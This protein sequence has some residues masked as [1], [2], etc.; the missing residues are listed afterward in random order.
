MLSHEFNDAIK[1]LR[2]SKTDIAKV[3]YYH[4]IIEEARNPDPSPC[5]IAVEEYSTGRSDI[6]GAV[7][8]FLRLAIGLGGIEWLHKIEDIGRTGRKFTSGDFLE[9]PHR[10]YDNKEFQKMWR[11]YVK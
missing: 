10:C 1:Q 8:L 7:A 11:E 2:L 3:I 9:K 5:V 4:C 6:P